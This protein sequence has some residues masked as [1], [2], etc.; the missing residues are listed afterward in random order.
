VGNNK[1]T[2][3]LTYHSNFYISE[4]F[5]NGIDLDSMVKKMLT[6]GFQATNV[7]LAIAEIEKMVLTNNLN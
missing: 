6:T 1:F 7:A 4:D 3:F 5:S 2:E